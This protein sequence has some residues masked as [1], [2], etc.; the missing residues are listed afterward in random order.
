MRGAVD[1][2]VEN[3]IL[4]RFPDIASRSSEDHI[5]VT[6]AKIPK[7]WRR[8]AT[9][10]VTMTLTQWG[11]VSYAEHK[12][13]GDLGV[14]KRVRG[15]DAEEGVPVE[16]LR[17]IGL[18]KTLSPHPNVIQ[19]LDEFFLPD[20]HDYTTE[21]FTMPRM[22][23]CLE[24]VTCD[25]R[26]YILR[27][28]DYT[29][30]AP[31][32]QSLTYQL[33]KGLAWCHSHLVLHRDLKPQNVLVD[34]I[35]GMLKLCDFGLARVIN[36]APGRAYTLEVVTLW[37]R[38][39][40]L[41]L[42]DAHYDGAIDV[43]SAGAVIAEMIT[44]IPLFPSSSEIDELF[45]IFR[46]LGTPMEPAPA[47]NVTPPCPNPWAGRPSWPGVSQLPAFNDQWPRWCRN[48]EQGLATRI[49]PIL[50]DAGVNLVESC[51]LYDPQS[52]PTAH[53]ALV[54]PFF[55]DFNPQMAGRVPLL[56][57]SA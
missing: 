10:K 35:T 49:Q 30:S 55:D 22:Y 34:P 48:F 33:L 7:G 3:V 52:R 50:N 13:S 46:L 42:G 47:L 53:E 39:P 25:L 15:N 5:K 32:M 28:R 2:I 31:C 40:E 24:R 36:E 12:F 38:A 9:W 19:L 4:Q 6:Y 44:G 29:I 27:T 43:W 21:Q 14:L 41:L 17:E 57:L 54:H 20:L 1:D 26:Q 51:L 56:D 45:T 18:L 23:L 8:F 37:Y 16:A 11:D